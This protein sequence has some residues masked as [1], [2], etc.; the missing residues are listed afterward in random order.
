M[1]WNTEYKYHI[2]FH[3]RL[4]PIPSYTEVINI[5]RKYSIKE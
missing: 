3:I 5:K 4:T 2:C 1:E